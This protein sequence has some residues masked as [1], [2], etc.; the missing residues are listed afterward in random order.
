MANLIPFTICGTCSSTKNAVAGIEIQKKR[1]G[2]D[3]FGK[4]RNEDEKW[5]KNEITKLKL[6]QTPSIVSKIKITLPKSCMYNP[7]Y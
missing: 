2:G 3:I 5:G 4:D 6:T 7:F 1:N